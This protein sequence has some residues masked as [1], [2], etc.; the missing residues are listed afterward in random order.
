M[1]QLVLDYDSSQRTRKLLKEVADGSGQDLLFYSELR[2][3]MKLTALQVAEMM[4]L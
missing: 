4:N 3:G 1:R 2:L